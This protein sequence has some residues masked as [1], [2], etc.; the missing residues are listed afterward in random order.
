MF[1]PTLGLISM[2]HL[3]IGWSPV[4]EWVS[5]EGSATDCHCH[6]EE[7]DQSAQMTCWSTHRSQLFRRSWTKWNL[8]S[9]VGTW[10]NDGSTYQQWTT[11]HPGTVWPLLRLNDG[12]RPTPHINV[13]CTK[14]N[15][16]RVDVLFEW[17]MPFFSD[18][19]LSN[20]FNF[21]IIF[22]SVDPIRGMKIMAGAIVFFACR[23]FV[24]MNRDRGDFGTRTVPAEL[25]SRAFRQIRLILYYS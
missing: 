23:F 18:Q 1:N 12:V 6:R 5:H 16:G 13:H 19:Y 14:V 9:Q 3:A 7:P 20:P 22:A 10:S 25:V 4:S 24:R 15:E 2:Y 11:V 17:T 21:L 8:F